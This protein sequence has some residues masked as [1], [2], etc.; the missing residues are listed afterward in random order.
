MQL[1]ATPPTQYEDGWVQLP[2]GEG[3]LEAYWRSPI[4]DTT[5]PVAT[6]N[7]EATVTWPVQTGP[8]PCPVLKYDDGGIGH[9]QWLN[10]THNRAAI[11][12]ADGGWKVGGQYRFWVSAGAGTEPFEISL[13]RFTDF[14]FP[15]GGS[16]EW[17]AP[18]DRAIAAAQA[19]LCLKQLEVAADVPLAMTDLHS[20]SRD[21]IREI[22]KHIFRIHERL[23]HTPGLADLVAMK[24][25]RRPFPSRVQKETLLEWVARLE[26]LR[27]RLRMGVPAW[28]VREEAANLLATMNAQWDKV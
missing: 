20:D 11:V 25:M 23:N 21:L 3:P 7:P 28:E 10:L 5:T 15:R 19:L 16:H 6:T 14:A 27:S 24:L 17:S 13:G 12:I 4:A 9:V 22:D 26:T 18:K 1:E 8:V 2:N